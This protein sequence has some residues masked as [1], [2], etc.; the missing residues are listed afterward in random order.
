MKRARKSKASK[1]GR[2]RRTRLYKGI[3]DLFDLPEELLLD[4]PQIRVSGK[5]YVFVDNH[6][7][8]V[9]YQN[10]RIR[11]DTSAGTLLI[12]GDGLVLKQLGMERLT[13]HGVIHAVEYAQ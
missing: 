9:E 1:P 4:V 6:K 12:K 2:K 13:I 7:G 5:E 8:I 10:T 11:L 3:S